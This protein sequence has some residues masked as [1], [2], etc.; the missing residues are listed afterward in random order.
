MKAKGSDAKYRFLKDLRRQGFLQVEGEP[1]KKSNDKNPDNWDEHTK[2]YK[3]FKNVLNDDNEANVPVHQELNKFFT[4]KIPEHPTHQ[5]RFKDDP[6]NNPFLFDIMARPIQTKKNSYAQGHYIPIT[7]TV[8]VSAPYGQLIEGYKYQHP[9]RATA[10]EFT[11]WFAHMLG[12]PFNERVESYHQKYGNSSNLY[13]ALGAKLGNIYGK[14]GDNHYD[15][16]QANMLERLDFPFNFD[17]LSDHDNAEQAK[18]LYDT[19]YHQKN[20]YGEHGLDANNYPNAYR[21][22]KTKLNQLQE[23]FPPEEE[24][25]LPN[26]LSNIGSTTNKRHIAPLSS[27]QQQQQ[28]TNQNQPDQEFIRKFNQI[29]SSPNRHQKAVNRVAQLPS[30]RLNQQSLQGLSQFGSSQQQYDQYVADHNQEHNRSGPLSRESWLQ[31]QMSNTGQNLQQR[32]QN[33]FQQTSNYPNA[34]GSQSQQFEESKKARGGRV[35]ASRHQRSNFDMQRAMQILELLS[36]GM[37]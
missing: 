23:D 29:N 9:Q 11:H 28:I 30:V 24:E 5:Y 19:L 15:E 22:Y 8:S 37:A 3:N 16:L 2:I 17:P 12:K 14:A 32:P 33:Q 1:Y 7:N 25:E 34:Y 35:T 20:L 36:R 31:Q 21:A 26:F 13:N 18:V 6:I 27:Q 4:S 10:H